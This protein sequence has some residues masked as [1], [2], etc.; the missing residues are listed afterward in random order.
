MGQ[1]EWMN[2][3]T[4]SITYEEKEKGSNNKNGTTAR[5]LDQLRYAKEGNATQ[6]VQRGHAYQ[7][8]RSTSYLF[9]ATPR[10]QPNVKRSENNDAKVQNREGKE[11]RKALAVPC[12]GK[13]GAPL[14]T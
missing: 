13:P 10:E 14:I 7:E 11:R 5:T 6:A 12:W 3:W 2:E 4:G 9:E 8:E 1:A